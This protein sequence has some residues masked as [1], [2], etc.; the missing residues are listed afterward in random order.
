MK[1]L[2]FMW[3]H[4]TNFCNQTF[5]MNKRSRGKRHKSLLRSTRQTGTLKDI[6]GTPDLVKTKGFYLAE[7][8]NFCI[9]SQLI[10]TIVELTNERA[11]L[12]KISGSLRV[13]T[14]KITYRLLSFVTSINVPGA[15][16]WILLLV[17]YLV[18]L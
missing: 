11:T 7:S 3:N 2:Y 8:V 4:F 9:R 14:D 12:D 10:T 5:L 13:I 15:I 1:E 6:F 16:S 17:I 18:T